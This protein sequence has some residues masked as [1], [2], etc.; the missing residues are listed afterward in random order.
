MMPHRGSRYP[1]MPYGDDPFGS[2]G[3]TWQIDNH[4]RALQ[5]ATEK[6]DARLYANLTADLIT[7]VAPKLPKD[8]IDKLLDFSVSVN[9][10]GMSKRDQ[11]RAYDAALWE[12]ARAAVRQVLMMLAEK[13]LYA[14]RDEAPEN[15][16]D[17]QDFALK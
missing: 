13:G 2:G 14:K 8:T 7:C 4:M 3:I 12:K 9:T 17:A 15:P 1:F 6:D 11:R 16:I 5:E 10:R